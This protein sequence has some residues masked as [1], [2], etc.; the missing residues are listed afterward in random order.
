MI[1]CDLDKDQ[2]TRPPLIWDSN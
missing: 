1:Y 2:S